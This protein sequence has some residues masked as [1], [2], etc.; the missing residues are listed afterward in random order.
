MGSE[1]VEPNQQ[2]KLT[3]A[4]VAPKAHREILVHAV[5]AGLTPLIPVPFVDDWARDGI[6]TRMVRCIATAH[7]KLLYESDQ[8]ALGRQTG[9]D[10]NQLLTAAKKLAFFPLRRLL[11]SALFMLLLRDVVEVASRTYHVGYLVDYVI[12]QQ[13]QDHVKAETLREAIDTVCR[14]VDTSPVRRAFFS[15]FEESKDLFGAAV[16]NLR[17]WTGVGST[18]RDHPREV[19][20]LADRLQRAVRILPP[21]HFDALRK[22]LEEALQ[23]SER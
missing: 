23:Q 19:E 18:K 4:S 9:R 3:Y 22:A 5:M 2:R 1:P 14:E 20:A 10:E 11:R 12:G 17:S 7:D 15:V 6:Q 13:L 21:E 8:K 16:E